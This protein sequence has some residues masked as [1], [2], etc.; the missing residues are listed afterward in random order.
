MTRTRILLADDHTLLLDA[1]KSLLEP[2]FEV[3]GTVTDG[4]AALTL[5]QKL[6][7]DVV[8]LDIAMP[9]LNG[10]EAARQF[11]AIMPHLK[12]VFVTMNPDPDMAQEA[13]KV[14]ASGYLLKTSAASELIKAIREVMRGLKYVTPTIQRGLD[15]AF[16]DD[17]RGEKSP[18]VISSRQREVLQ[19]LAEGRPMK[20]VADILN[21]TPRTVAYHKYKVMAD[22]H[23]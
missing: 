23:L 1:F 19:L 15:E 6:K 21:L 7:P 20:Q 5:A 11:R 16:I 18:H 22:L 10:L 17:P 13:L 8:I 3:V 12:V 4:R 9:M 14:G 2:E